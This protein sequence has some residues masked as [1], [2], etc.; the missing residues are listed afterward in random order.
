MYDCVTPIAPLRI[1]E[2]TRT[3]VQAGELLGI[4]VLDY[5]VIGQGRFVRMRE[6]GLG[7]PS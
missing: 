7:F 3:L 6:R 1:R 4:D 5:L 2:V